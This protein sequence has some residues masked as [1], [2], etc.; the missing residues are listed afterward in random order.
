MRERG[1]WDRN[2]CWRQLPALL[3]L[4][5]AALAEAA[6]PEL[7]TAARR[8][9]FSPVVYDGSYARIPYPMGDVAPD[10]GVCTDVIIRAYRALGIDLQALVH[11]D[12]RRSFAAYPPLWGLVRPDPNIDHRRVPNL[13]RFFER[14]G[15][16]VEA[17]AI[18]SG[19]L[20]G[21]LVT[22]RLPGNLPHIGMISDRRN[23]A[24]GTPLVIHNIGAGP[25]EDDILF[26]YPLTGHYRYKLK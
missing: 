16:A 23:A 19:Y 1:E 12:M 14:A 2:K 20:P 26:S 10:R 3:L 25:V 8:Q 5:M 22:W 6:S 18:A 21:D 11:E 4:A 17:P 24:T 9:T 7:V 13:Q 15:A